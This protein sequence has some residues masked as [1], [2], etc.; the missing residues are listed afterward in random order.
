MIKTLKRLRWESDGKDT[1]R[2][3]KKKRQS[4]DNGNR[5][6]TSSID[7]EIISP[8]SSRLQ[9]TRLETP[10][11]NLPIVETASIHLLFFLFLPCLLRCARF[12]EID[13]RT[14]C[15]AEAGVIYVIDVRSHE[16]NIQYFSSTASIPTQKIRVELIEMEVR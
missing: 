4:Y 10:F 7:E 8:D 11:S 6:R 5:S 13:L 14:L 16:R 9:M 12:L 3:Q 15:A 1:E 2:E